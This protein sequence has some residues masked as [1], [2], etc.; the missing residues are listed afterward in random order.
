MKVA[1]LWGVVMLFLAFSI[2]YADVVDVDVYSTLGLLEIDV[3]HYMDGDIASHHWFM[4]KG[5][6]TVNFTSHR[7]DAANS[8]YDEL[9]T[10]IQATGNGPTMFHTK[11]FQDFDKTYVWGGS[12]PEYEGQVEAYVF[13]TTGA[14]MN[15]GS[16]NFATY[17]SMDSYP[18][19][20]TPAL[21]AS[22]TGD[23]GYYELATSAIAWVDGEVEAQS[24]IAVFGSGGTAW[25]S[26]GYKMKASQG[27]ISLSSCC[28]GKIPPLGSVWGT[29][30]Y[31][32]SGSGTYIRN[33]FG[34]DYVNS[35]FG[36]FPGGASISATINFFNGMLAKPWTQAH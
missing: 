18:A 14:M 24:Q 19:W 12:P 33:I 9:V 22:G 30:V 35:E 10:G 29:T 2:T 1:G 23:N 31:V 27:S 28:L 15:L 21:M 7:N 5:D 20:S 4:A 8:W 32:D 13:G 6:F 17:V 25:Q 3:F 36:E 26:F 11:W 34:A 16:G